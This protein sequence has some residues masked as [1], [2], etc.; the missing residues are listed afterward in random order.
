MFGT[1]EQET[2]S[3]FCWCFSA[4]RSIDIYRLYSSFSL[5]QHKSHLALIPIASAMYHGAVTRSER[6][7]A[8][9]LAALF[10]TLTFVLPGDL[11]M[12]VVGSNSWNE[13]CWRRYPGWWFGCHQFYFPIN[14]GLL[15]I[16]IDELIFFRGVQTNHQ[17][18]LPCWSLLKECI[19]Y[20]RP[21]L[22]LTLTSQRFHLFVAYW[23]VCVFVEINVSPVLNRSFMIFDYSTRDHD[24][25]KETCWT[26]M[27]VFCCFQY[28]YVYSW[29]VQ[30]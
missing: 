13:T 9:I 1:L 28:M 22:S 6:S 11:G 29:H 23:N 30:I 20:K 4:H 21:V 8:P 25:L 7:N 18:V 15:I 14:I 10:C 24:K 17:P 2:P 12:A 26:C 27:Y 3:C 5:N 19:N 16:P